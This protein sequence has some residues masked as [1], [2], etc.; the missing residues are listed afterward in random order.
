MKNY[1]VSLFSLTYYSSKN[2]YFYLILKITN[3]PSHPNQLTH[4]KTKNHKITALMQKPPAKPLWTKLHPNL[5]KHISNALKH[6]PP[7]LQQ[8]NPRPTSPSAIQI[9]RPKI[10]PFHLHLR[11]RAN[12]RMPNKTWQNHGPRADPQRRDL[13]KTGDLHVP[14][15][16][17]IEPQQAASRPADKDQT[18]R[19]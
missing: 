5:R 11:N 3:N 13:R 12:L 1:Q 10:T 14:K 19:F 8:P 7:A 15:I 9:H 16:I 17:K 18:I 2:R 4:S 6:H